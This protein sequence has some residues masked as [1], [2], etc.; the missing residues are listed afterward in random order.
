M[1][2]KANDSIYI[3]DMK[4]VCEG[5]GMVVNLKKQGLTKLEYFAS[6]AM[7]GF[8]TNPRHDCMEY[9]HEE[10]AQMAVKQAKALINALN[11]GE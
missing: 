9:P 5:T 2:T 3:T 6:Q 4:D 10:M 1:K 11:K 8:C 7:Q